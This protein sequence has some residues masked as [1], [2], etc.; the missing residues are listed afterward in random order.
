MRAALDIVKRPIPHESLAQ[1]YL[2]KHLRRF[3]RDTHREV[4][5]VSGLAGNAYC[6]GKYPVLEQRHGGEH[7]RFE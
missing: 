5:A 3:V 7:A 4:V 1:T 6:S 2:M